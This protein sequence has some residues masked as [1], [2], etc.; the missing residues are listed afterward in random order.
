METTRMNVL[1]NHRF[2]IG[3]P[4]AQLSKSDALCHTPHTKLVCGMGGV[5]HP[6]SASRRA[7][8]HPTAKAGGYF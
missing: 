4:Y 1:P 6:T 7:Q 8:I 2:L 5:Y 3:T